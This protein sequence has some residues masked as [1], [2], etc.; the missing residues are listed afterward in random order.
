[1]AWLSCQHYGRIAFTADIRSPPLQDEIP[2]ELHLGHVASL[3]DAITFWSDVDLEGN[4]QTYR[5][6][7]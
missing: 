4:L 6:M 2:F 3:G 7:V 5:T 1:M